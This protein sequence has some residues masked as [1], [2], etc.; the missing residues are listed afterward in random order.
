VLPSKILIPIKIPNTHLLDFRPVLRCKRAMGYV[1]AYAAH[2]FELFAFRSWIV[3]YLSFASINGTSGN[4]QWNITTIVALM[5]LF[6]FPASVIG[7]ELA[8]RL[9]RHKTITFVMLISA[10][11]AFIIGFSVHW[12]FWII[13]LISFIYFTAI[14]ADSAA[15]TAGVVSAAPDGYEGTTMS[16][17]SC[18]GF[19]G[20]FAGPL[21]FGVVLDLTSKLAIG[22]P[23]VYAFI[24]IGTIGMLGSLSLFLL[25]DR[26]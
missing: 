17:Y 6:G 12:P 14:I 23:W 3:A 4:S 21:M 9:G 5:N 1:L 2:N 8:R 7:N 25:P 10:I 18:I 24:F 16:V 26:N 22:I 11:F 15:L 19:T 13:V 20:S